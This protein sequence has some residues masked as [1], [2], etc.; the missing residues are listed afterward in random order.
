MKLIKS[1]FIEIGKVLKPIYL[2]YIPIRKNE[3]Q[4]EGISFG[5]P[6]LQTHQISI[7]KGSDFSP[8]LIDSLFAL[9]REEIS[10]NLSKPIEI[11]SILSYLEEILSFYSDIEDRIVEDEN[12]ILTTDLHKFIK[13]SSQKELYFDEYEEFLKGLKKRL[14]EEIQF[15]DGQIKHFEL[16]IDKILPSPNTIFK[17]NDLS[18]ERGK[19]D[20]IELSRALSLCGAI[21]KSGKM[22]NLTDSYKLFGELFNIEL[23]N[24]EDQLRERSDSLDAPNF[25]EV[26]L[27]KFEEDQKFLKK[28]RES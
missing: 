26:L 25:L 6:D 15:V 22:L 11:S 12:G 28:K 1:K 5:E 19:V 7:V 16:S 8:V 20:L 17:K 21:K 13:T 24:P 27:E 10:S 23:K 2:T 18:W 9:V 4:K 14:R 3:G